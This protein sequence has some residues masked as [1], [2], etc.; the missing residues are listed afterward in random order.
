MDLIALIVAIS[1]SG[2][3]YIRDKIKQEEIENYKNEIILVNNLIIKSHKIKFPII[4]DPNRTIKLILKNDY[5]TIQTYLTS[6]K[7]GVAIFDYYIEHDCELTGY[8]FFDLDEN[9]PFKSDKQ[10]SIT[11]KTDKDEVIEYCKKSLKCENVKNTINKTSL[12]IHDDNFTLAM[13]FKN[14]KDNLN[15]NIKDFIEF[16]VKDNELYIQLLK[17]HKNLSSI[18][19]IYFNNKKIAYFGENYKVHW[20]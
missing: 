18:V 3:L 5:Q 2:S 1:I 13:F 14:D 17:E 8:I 15:D 10:F 16:S 11:I 4:T 6:D 7:D 12:E 9:Q 20:F 19:D